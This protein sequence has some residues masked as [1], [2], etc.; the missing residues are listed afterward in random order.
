V[1]A[2]TV[3]VHGA[4]CATVLAPGP[5]LPADAAT[6]TPAAVALKNATSTAL[7]IDVVE[8]EIE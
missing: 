4:L 3:A 1:L 2:A 5:L 8:P 7:L 6:N